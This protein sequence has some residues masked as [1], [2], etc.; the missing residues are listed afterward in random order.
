MIPCKISSSS[1]ILPCC[2]TI[3]IGI[4]RIEEVT[5][6]NP[7]RILFIISD[8]GGGHR[9]AANA[10][11]ATLRLRDPEI[12]CEALDLLR[13]SGLPGLKSAPE[14]YQFFSAGHMWLYNLLFGLFNSRWFMDAASRLLYWPA[15]KRIDT[16]VRSFSPDL[17]VVIHPL[18][19]RP[20]CAYRDATNAKWRVITVVTDLVSIH[21]SW[22]S[23]TADLYL[24]PTQEA[25]ELALSHGIE[26]AKTLLTGFPVHPRFLKPLP[27]AEAVRQKLSLDPMRFTVLFTSGGAGGGNVRHLIETLESRCPDLQLLIVTGRNENLRQRLSVRNNPPPHTHIFGFVD[28]MEELMA[29]A[30]VVVGKAGP[31]T[32]MEA[33][34][35]GKQL[36]LTGAVGRQE[37]GN[38]GFA[39]RWALGVHLSDPV[40]ITEH[41]CRISSLPDRL[42]P[43]PNQWKQ[44]TGTGRIADILLQ[45]IQ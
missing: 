10:I 45:H 18:L 16:A 28:N 39:E 35:C 6:L 19:V 4:V 5:R 20:M 15:K 9:S 44:L 1:F 7:S 12:V 36:V 42:E 8:T 33:A 13:A 41:L 40:A 23:P 26:K 22:F 31:G 3:L 27:A 2:A 37:E 21:A 38:L 43:R 14:L 30:D 24:L 34:A 32:V 29:A 25:C 11:I 17:V